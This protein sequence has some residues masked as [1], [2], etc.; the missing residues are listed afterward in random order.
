MAERSLEKPA[1][2]RPPDD[3]GS[4][5]ARRPAGALALALGA[6]SFVIAAIAHGELSSMPDLWLTVPG[7]ALTAVA[8]G[9]SLARREPRAY[10]LWAIGLGL[11][12][13]AIVLG[14]FLMLAIVIGVT[15][16]AILILHA[17]M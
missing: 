9:A 3:G 16:I 11:A 6:L 17:V 1:H 14:W 2:L 13:A 4:W 7:F 8:A 10:L 5:L 12:G 15:A